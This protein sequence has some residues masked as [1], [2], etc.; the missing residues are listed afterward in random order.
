MSLSIESK[1]VRAVLLSDGWHRVKDHSFELESYEYIERGA[2]QDKDPFVLHGGG[3]SGICATGF[4]CDTFGGR[5]GH[6]RRIAGPLTS[7]LA[8][9]I[10]LD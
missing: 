4:I 9:E 7:I 2:A 10:D 5:D 6:G 8:V 1:T 3:Q